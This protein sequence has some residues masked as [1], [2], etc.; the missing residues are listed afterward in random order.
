M[1][2][3]RIAPVKENVV[4]T[5]LGAAESP[6]CMAM[7]ADIQR[8]ARPH[9][10]RLLIDRSLQGSMLAEQAVVVAGATRVEAANEHHQPGRVRC[11]Q[12]IMT[13]HGAAPLPAQASGWPEGSSGATAWLAAAS[14]RLSGMATITGAGHRRWAISP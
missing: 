12:S 13:A 5:A 10:I 4:A 8:S 9:R 7:T 1:G 6:L 2:A 11:P 14:G 3:H